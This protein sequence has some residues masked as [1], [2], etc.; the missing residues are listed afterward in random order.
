M[1]SAIASSSPLPEALTEREA[2]RLSGMSVKFFQHR[3]AVGH[4]GQ[5]IPGP[6]YYRIGRAI[7]YPRQDFMAWLESYRVESTPE[8]RQ[9]RSGV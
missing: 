3:R 1:S 9:R 5:G 8:A 4:T 7:R 2:A 6:P